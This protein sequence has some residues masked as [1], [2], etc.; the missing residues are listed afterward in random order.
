M[1]T[2][3]NPKALGITLSGATDASTL[4]Y[5]PPGAGGVQTIQ[6][7]WNGR[8]ASVFDK[9]SAAQRADVTAGTKSLDVT[10]AVQAAFSDAT[11]AGGTLIFPKGTYKI[12]STITCTQ[13]LRILCDPGAIFDATTCT[14]NPIFNIY[15]SPDPLGTSHTNPN[16][17]A[18]CDKSDT[19][20]ADLANTL[21]AGNFVILSTNPSYGG[22]GALWYGGRQTYYQ[23]EI[24]LVQ[25][26]TVPVAT[27]ASPV[28]DSYGAGAAGM[29]KI[30]PVTID[31]QG[32][33][34]LGSNSHSEQAGVEIQYGLNCSI[35]KVV[36]R[37]FCHSGLYCL[38]CYN[39]TV[40]DC[41]IEATYFSG[42]GTGYS[43]AV[44]SCQIFTVK[45]G[46]YI[47][48]RAGISG[49]G[50]EPVRDLVLTGAVF[51]NDVNTGGGW[52]LDMH[53]NVESM[54][55]SNCIFQDGCSD[56]AKFSRFSDCTFNL[57]KYYVSITTDVQGGSQ[58]GWPAGSGAGFQMIG[59]SINQM[60]N[61]TSAQC[62]SVS[63]GG[64]FDLV[65]VNGCELNGQQGKLG[66]II[67]GAAITE[68]DLSHTQ[69]NGVSNGLCF[70]GTSLTGHLSVDHFCSNS[71][72]Y[73]FAFYSTTSTITQLDVCDSTFSNESHNT[74]F[75]ST[76]GLVR[77]RFS[78]NRYDGNGD[79]AISI[80]ASKYIECKDNY[81]SNFTGGGLNLVAPNVLIADNQMVSVTG[82]ANYGGRYYNKMGPTGNVETWALAPTGPTSGYWLQGDHYW[83]TGV[84]ASNTPFYACTGTGYSTKGTGWA[85]GTAYTAGQYVASNGGAWMA[86]NSAISGTTA[87]TGTANMSDGAVNWQYIGAYTAVQ[88][89][90]MTNM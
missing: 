50:W 77:A 19:I 30:L 68:F 76:A 2:F 27:W 28:R 52:S 72:G 38:R 70:G 78:R 62:L 15:G 41:S 3:T 26:V 81:I 44:G 46:R 42:N 31:W 39:T 21:A 88:W 34:I 9:F 23:G 12:T 67:S 64:T 7:E 54:I 83:N 84:T 51:D 85:S 56:C 20:D 79:G 14:S 58:N 45:G 37:G 17:I 8:M 29:V 75:A 36:I 80:I 59:C 32:G 24:L 74:V 48:A 90:A 49:G 33:T 61:G 11:L 65:Q 5:T 69:I 18:A 66:I 63:N 87:P 22:Q 10:A 89:S 57:R 35:S 47:G 4:T 53:G 82:T 71:S 16:A 55:A 1:S 13:S 25:S 43:I 40:N 86:L 73:H 6:S 60:P